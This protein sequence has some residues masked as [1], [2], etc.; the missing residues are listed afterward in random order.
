M[1][2][3]TLRICF[4]ILRKSL[5]FVYFLAALN[6]VVCLNPEIY[7]VIGGTDKGVIAS[8]LYQSV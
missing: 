8:I 5:K 1:F 2:F 7:A 6:F 3:F 4:Q